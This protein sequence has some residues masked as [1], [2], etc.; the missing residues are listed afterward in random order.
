MLAPEVRNTSHLQLLTSLLTMWH[1]PLPNKVYKQRNWIVLF[2]LLP[3]EGHTTTV[4]IETDSFSLEHIILVWVFF[5]SPKSYSSYLKSC[6]HYWLLVSIDLNS[7]Q[8][9]VAGSPLLRN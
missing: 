1:Y 6:W 2:L 9:R 3:T 4:T 8:H 7:K 5:Y